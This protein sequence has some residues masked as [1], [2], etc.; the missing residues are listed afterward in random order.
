MR[1]WVLAMVWLVAAARADWPQFLGV[2]RDGKS[3]EQ[4]LGR[5]LSKVGVAWAHSRG[6]SYSAPSISGNRLIHH[7]RFQGLEKVQCLDAATG[8]LLWSDEYPTNYRDRFN[9]LSGPRASPAIKGDRVYALGVQGILSCYQLNDGHLVWRRKLAGEFAV[10]TE[11]FGFTPSPLIEGNSIIVNLGMGKCVAAFD[12]ST[13]ETQWISGEQ[14]GRSYASPVAA[15]MHGRRVLLV[16]AGGESS[17]PVGGLLCV[18]PTTGKIHDRFAWR[19]PR[20]A[21]ANASTPVVSGNRVFISSSYDVGGVML[22]VQPDFTLKEVYRTKAYASHWATPILVGDHLYGFANNKLVCMEWE[23]GKRVWR[24]VPKIGSAAFQPPEASGRGADRYRPPVGDGGFGIGSLIHAD[25]HF[26]CLGE[27]GLLA[28]MDLSPDGCTI[29]SSVRLFT[30]GQ[31]WTAPV[32]S[33]GRAYICQN[34]PGIGTEPRLICLDLKTE[35]PN[36]K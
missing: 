35:N 26:L 34:L 7:A 17:P 1:L 29:L 23:T 8:E 15:T 10:D 2:D 12:K 14:W 24:S 11:F 3:V 27:T 20:H 30:A 16:F 31:T 19:S 33:N 25:G 22:E 9:Y 21:S 36:G 6:E 13:G 28:W 4:G 5:D 32:V 18:D